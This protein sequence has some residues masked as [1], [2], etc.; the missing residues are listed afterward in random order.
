MRLFRGGKIAGED[1][2]LLAD[3]DVL[4]DGDG[5]IARVGIFDAPPEIEVIDCSGKI[6]VPGMFDMHVHSRDPGQTHQENLETCSCAALHGGITGMA[7][8]PDTN[9]PIDTGNLVRAS[10]TNAE[11]FSPVFVHQM[12]AISR[13]LEGRELAAI[14]GMA[15][16]GVPMLTDSAR[17][18]TSPLFFMRAMEYA[19]DFDLP[20]AACGDVDEMSRG[21]AL[22]EGPVSYRLGLPGIPSIAEEIGIDRYIRIAQYTRGHLHL[23][24]VSTAVGMKAI[25][26][27][28]ADGIDVTCEVSPHHLIFCEEDIV[29]YDTNFKTWPPLRTEEDSNLLL[30]GLMEGVFDVIATNHSPHTR[31]EKATDFGSAPFGI[32]GLETAVVSLY[33]RFIRNDVFGWDVLVRHYS[34]EPR[35]LLKRDPVPIRENR[36]ADFFV[37]DPAGETTPTESTMQSK[38]ANTPW[39]GQTLAGRICEVVRWNQVLKT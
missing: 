28:K 27:A 12:G 35:R 34:S 6:L 5:V 19:S 38:S 29:N 32:T 24:Q 15:E 3:G 22:N 21:R 9:P 14:A 39:I 18:I 7:L 31:Y 36:P 8:M 10:L 1:S 30:H 26:R 16:A 11:L 20:L 17:T 25:Q 2:P 13:G 23:Q 4:V 37:F 33:D